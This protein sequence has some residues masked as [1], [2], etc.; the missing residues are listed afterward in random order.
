MLEVNIFDTID[1]EQINKQLELSLL[2]FKEEDWRQEKVDHHLPERGRVAELICARPESQSEQ[3]VLQHRISMI[4]A[5]VALCRVQETPP[6]QKRTH[7]R[8]WGIKQ[9]DEP[10]V[11]ELLPMIYPTSQCPLCF[12]QFSRSHKFREHVERMYLKQHPV[13]ALILCSHP[14]CLK[15]RIVLVGKAHSKNHAAQVH[16]SF[17]SAKQD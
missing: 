2:G 12:R 17:L 5:L 16:K 15:K 7:D 13:D 6:T 14:R 8:D 10:P 1:T 4:E 9:Q 11:V 3:A